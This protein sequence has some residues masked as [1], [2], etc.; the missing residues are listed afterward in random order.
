MMK[1]IA[2]AFSRPDAMLELGAANKVAPCWWKLVST[3]LLLSWIM[4]E[5][6][7]DIQMIPTLSTAVEPRQHNHTLDGTHGRFVGRS[8][9]WI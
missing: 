5:R 9:K 3:G 8:H 7:A 6:V 4:L 2:A 1:Q